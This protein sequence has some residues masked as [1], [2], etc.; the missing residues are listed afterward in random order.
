MKKLFNILILC[1]IYLVFCSKSC[2]DDSDIQVVQEK[3][4]IAARDSIRD[5]FETG[6]LSEDA[7]NGAEVKAMQE[8]N[9]LTDYVEIFTDSSLDR[10]FREKAGEMI[11]NMFDSKDSRISFYA[12][13]NKKLNTCTLNEFLTNGQRKNDITMKLAFDSIRVAVPLQKS[14]ED[15]YSGRL[16]AFQTVS[17]SGPEN[18]YSISYPVSINFVSVKRSKII[19]KDTLKVWEVLFKDMEVSK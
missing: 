12:F 15:I 8:L 9:D 17:Y 16:S 10:L 11:N 4:A 1:L 13:S 7:R 5:E 6:Y 2:S 18:S 14:G 19:G 3:Q